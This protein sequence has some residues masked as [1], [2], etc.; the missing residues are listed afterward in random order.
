MEKIKRD[1]YL[2]KLIDRQK[3]GLIKIITGI[4][5]C[6]IFFGTLLRNTQK[7]YLGIGLSKS[8]KFFSK[9]VPKNTQKM[10][11]RS[12]PKSTIKKTSEHYGLIVFASFFF[13]FNKEL[14]KYLKSTK[15][16]KIATFRDYTIKNENSPKNKYL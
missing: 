9:P 8:L 2:Q 5:R 10:F 1:M 4:R 12:V 3:N 16:T 7:M 13:A 6:G 14:C 11:P 15:T